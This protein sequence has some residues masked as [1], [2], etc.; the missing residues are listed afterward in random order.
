MEK[1]IEI[2]Y[3]NS[4]DQLAKIFIEMLSKEKLV[5]LK[6]YD[7][8]QVAQDVQCGGQLQTQGSSEL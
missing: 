7:P 8:H 6:R 3:W 4:K 2:S 1:D 5:S